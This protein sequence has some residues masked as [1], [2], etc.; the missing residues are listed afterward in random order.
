MQIIFHDWDDVSTALPPATFGSKGNVQ[1]W[2][3]VLPNDPLRVREIS[4][5]L[6]RDEKD[7]ASCYLTEESQREFLY[8]RSVLRHLLGMWAGV[9]PGA[10]MFGYGPGGKPFLQFPQTEVALQFNLSHSSGRLV[11][12]L[13][14]GRSVGVDI[15][16]VRCEMD[17]LPVA[18]RCF[19]SEEL[20]SLLTL[21]VEQRVSDFFKVWTCKEAFLKATGQGLI[22]NMADIQVRL[23]SGLD[24]ELQ[25]SPFAGCDPRKWLMRTIPLPAGFAG[26]LAVEELLPPEAIET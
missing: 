21:P 4:N 26:T 6:S 9:E 13:S 12:A 17:W 8:G 1:I 24:P 11:I 3:A 16:R 23:H 15:E 2:R 25:A 10:L 20:E 7:R 19:S 18:R 22:E 5:C 14:E